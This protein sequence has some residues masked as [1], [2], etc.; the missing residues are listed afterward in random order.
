M[1]LLTKIALVGIGL[2][3]AATQAQTN[4]G[5]ESNSLTGWTA[6]SVGSQS[7][8]G[9][10]SN[11][12]GVSVVTGIVNY[13]PGGGNTWNVTPY[14]SY[15]AA[16]QAGAGAVTFDNMTTSLGLTATQNQSIKSMLVTQSQTGGGNPTPTN[17]AWVR[18]DVT[19]QA[20]TTYKFAWQYLSTD[21]TPFNDGSI[22]TLVH[23]TDASKIP[24]LN[25]TNNNYALL[26]FTNPGTGNYSTG[27]YSA[28]GWQ[29]AVFTV[30]VDGDYT[31]GF[32]SF[33]LGDTALSPILLIDEMQGSTALNGQSFGPVAPN[34]G[35][36]A[37]VTEST[38][39]LCCGGSS[40]PFSADPT[41]INNLNEFMNRPTADSRVYIEQIG[42]QNTTTIDQTGTINNYT[43][44]TSTGDS[45]SVTINQSSTVNSATNY[46]E[47]TVSGSSNTVDIEQN[48][49]GGVKSAFVTV[50]NNNN[51]VNLLQKDSGSHYAD[52]RVSGGNKTV[53]I[54]QEGSGNH[55]AKID[56]SGAATSISVN[57]A[58]ATQ[59]SYSIQ[60]SCAS[61]C[62]GITVV[63]GK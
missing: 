21:Y 44:Y 33:N 38:P 49:T 8:T 22:I 11:G 53:E 59:Q 14:G 37:P 24:V 25:N 30:P 42:N 27:S 61:S 39:T 7:A 19:L 57:Q 23:K 43:K 63:Q 1:S 29:L 12:Q 6:S 31:L 32:A 16:V 34:P 36:T 35:S 46:I 58:G 10:S 47:L 4:Y 15:M 48:S 55:M 5:F 40:A 62:A 60:H 54:V 51:S 56:L 26:G 28:T 41:H 20:G 3:A 2:F 17:A 9:W 50:T 13:N 18:R 52:V 45:N